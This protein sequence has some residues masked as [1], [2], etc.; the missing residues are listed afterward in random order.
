METIT[1]NM[2]PK[3]YCQKY[4]LFC[5][6][7]NEFGYCKISACSRPVTDF[8]ERKSLSTNFRIV[9]RKDEIYDLFDGTSWI[10]SRGCVDDILNYLSAMSKYSAIRI[11]FEDKSMEE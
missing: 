3:R 6:F 7:A 1:N 11:V 10:M 2:C 5:G 9:H 4:D 8:L